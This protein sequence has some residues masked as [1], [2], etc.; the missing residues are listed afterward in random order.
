MN[1][2]IFTNSQ[3]NSETRASMFDMYAR[4]YTAAGQE[5]WF[6][7]A[8]EMFRCA[9][10][11]V[12]HEHG[13][14]LVS[15]ALFQKRPK[16]NKICLVAHDGTADGKDYAIHL[17]DRLCR[18]EGW[19][20][21]ASDKP[22]WILRS[23][24]ETPYVTNVEDIRDILNI[25]ETEDIVLNPKFEK[26]PVLTR[27]RGLKAEGHYFHKYYSSADKELLVHSNPETLFGTSPCQRW[28]DA[29]CQRVCA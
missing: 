17:R 16:S 10:S 20:L 8:D 7:T 11:S 6:K 19:F 13:R 25:P 23:K 15:F 26:D 28:S 12:T 18:S 29:S 1:I 14:R 3:L 24:F 4:S 9:C 2:S 21:E 5:L 22:A 27:A